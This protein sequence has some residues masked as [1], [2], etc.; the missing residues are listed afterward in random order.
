MVPGIEIKPLLDF[1]L[2]VERARRIFLDEVLFADR[3]VDAVGPVMLWRGVED[4]AEFPQVGLED[5]APSE[6][7]FLAEAVYG[8]CFGQLVLWVAVL[9]VRKLI[10]AGPGFLVHGRRAH[11]HLLFM[12]H[13]DM[14]GGLVGKSGMARLAGGGAA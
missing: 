13:L 5:G 2:L 6:E 12:A 11:M 7:G 14:L 4:F 8:L 9:V 3:L 1:I 10:V